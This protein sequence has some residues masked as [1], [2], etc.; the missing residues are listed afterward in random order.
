MRRN[1]RV[2]DTS[3]LKKIRL[4]SIDNGQYRESSMDKVNL[5]HWS[6]DKISNI[7]LTTFWT[8]FFFLF[9]ENIEISMHLISM[10]SRRSDWW[11]DSIGWGSVLMPNRGQATN[12]NN[13]DQ[14]LQHHIMSLSLNELNQSKNFH[15]C[16]SYDKNY[17]NSSFTAN[18]WLALFGLTT[19]P[20]TAYQNHLTNPTM[21]Q[22]S[23]P[24][25]T[26]L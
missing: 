25:C 7:L 3:Y 14:E 16:Q 2:I 8:A 22:A 5:T 23:I 1:K 12:W 17:I 24:Q 10:C 18:D 19:R 13:D 11:Q 20:S 6:L 9:K 4:T 15:Y 21:H 26:I